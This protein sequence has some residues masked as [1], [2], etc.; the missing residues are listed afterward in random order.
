[1]KTQ[2]TSICS[3]CGQPEDSPYTN[4]VRQEAC[5]AKIHDGVF[6]NTVRNRLL[7]KWKGKRLTGK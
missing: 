2:T 7:K 3:V 1:M 5:V 4:N 6:T